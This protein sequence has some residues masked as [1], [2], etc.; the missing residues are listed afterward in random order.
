MSTALR[1]SL[2]PTMART[3]RYLTEAAQLIAN[4]EGM[5][6]AALADKSEHLQ[7]CADSLR[8]KLVQWDQ[9][10]TALP[11]EAARTAEIA[12]L[13]AF[14]SGEGETP[15]AL[16]DAALETAVTLDLQIDQLRVRQVPQGA[17]PVPGNP[18]NVH[19]GG[20]I[21]IPLPPTGL[22]D[23]DGTASRWPGFWANF[24]DQVENRPNLSN[25]QRLGYLV[26]QMRGIARDMLEGYPLTDQNYV[27]AVDALK[28][29]FGD[30]VRRAHELRA[31][32]LRLQPANSS[33]NSLRTLSEAVERLCRQLPGL[34]GNGEDSGFLITTLREKLPREVKI[35]L[36]EKEANSGHVWTS[37]EWRQG[38]ATLV[39]IRESAQADGGAGEHHQN[40]PNKN[41]GPNRTPR[42]GNGFRGG[43]QHPPRFGDRF[44]PPAPTNFMP[45]RAF[46]VVEA[47][48]SRRPEPNLRAPAKCS[49][50]SEMGHV[51]SGCPRFNTA[52][53][54]QR[55]LTDQRR[56][57]LCLREGHQIE[58]C[59]SPHRCSRCQGRH[60]VMVCSKT[61][62][63]KNGGNRFN[64]PPVMA[65][66][67]VESGEGTTISAPVHAEQPEKTP[68]AYLMVRE[69]NVYNHRNPTAP[70]KVP[71][72]LDTGGQ[73]SFITG[74]L[75]SEI[76]PR[77]V[78]TNHL[79]VVGFVG[80]GKQTPSRFESPRYS[81]LLEKEDGGWE[82][83]ILNRTNQITPPIDCL[84]GGDSSF[85]TQGMPVA[86]RLEPRIMIGIREFWR[87]ITNQSEIQPGLFRVDTA[88][89]PFFGGEDRKEGVLSALSTPV[90]CVPALAHSNTPNPLLTD[91]VS[92]FW[93]LEALGITDRPEQD[94]DQLAVDLSPGL[95]K[96]PGNTPLTISG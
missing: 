62:P 79:E 20:G 63:P 33:A 12:V 56:C 11:T 89:G 10:I 7:R 8:A 58:Q 40:L 77:K 15:A 83:L 9:N 22:L 43:N 78:A 65:H 93:S 48:A 52:G 50:C 49:L 53:K 34:N 95:G 28:A 25:A 84:V 1:Q 82:E 85:T 87:L 36:L 39:R 76:N 75:V 5:T 91:E 92:K 4:P 37:E 27:I 13:E 42:V 44:P 68:P 2:G 94:D 51:P 3:R 6:I 81:V 61:G 32:I 47:A 18:G 74:N 17:Q 19:P 59:T 41:F 29:R 46:P 70:V 86:Q 30:E 35:N 24:R 38:L 54:R 64:S 26:G 55:Q 16:M 14:R 31:E 73:M 23:F 21:F 96:F 80:D 66:P 88:F 69:V 45:R 60:H 57:H 72:F 67:V 71:V 90:C